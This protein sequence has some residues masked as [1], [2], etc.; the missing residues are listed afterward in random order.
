M[1]TVVLGS[2]VKEDFI[3]VCS[4][5]SS[6]P[7][8]QNLGNQ[9]EIPSLTRE[10]NFLFES[11]SLTEGEDAYYILPVAINEPSPDPTI[12]PFYVSGQLKLTAPSDISISGDNIS[13]DPNT[14]LGNIIIP[15][16]ASSRSIQILIQD[17]S[18]YET[19]KNSIITL[20]TSTGAKVGTKSVFSL[21]VDDNDSPP[22]ISFVAAT[23]TATEGVD[24]VVSISLELDAPVFQN[25]EIPINV[26]G[27]ALEGT[28]YIYGQNKIIVP[29]N[30]L[31][32][33]TSLT[34]L[35]DTSLEA[36]EDFIIEI[37]S[38]SPLPIGDIGTHTLTISDNDAKPTVS[39][40][41]IAKTVT[42]G[43]NSQVTVGITLSSSSDISQTIPFS[44]SGTSTNNV[45][46]TKVSSITI[47]AGETTGQLTIPI[48]NDEI[49]EVSETLIITMDNPANADPSAG[50]DVLTVTIND[51]DSKPQVQFK[52]HSLAVHEDEGSA[53]VYFQLDKLSGSDLNINY[54]VSGTAING[55]HYTLNDGDITIT[56]GND[57]YELSFP[58][59]ESA[60]H[61]SDTNIT[62]T[63][64]SGTGYDIGLKKQVTITRLDPFFEHFPH[65]T[66]G[67]EQLISN[68]INHISNAGETYLISTNQGLVFFDPATLKLQTITTSRGLPSMEVHKS[69]YNKNDHSLIV[70]TSAGAAVAQKDYLT[71]FRAITSA[72]S[73]G[74]TT[75]NFNDALINGNQIILGSS[76][77]LF[78]SENYGESFKHFNVGNTT[79]M[80]S[81]NIIKLEMINNEQ[82][83]MQT[84]NEVIIV[85]GSEIGDDAVTIS[86]D[87][88]PDEIAPTIIDFKL[89]D[90]NIYILTTNGVFINDYK[91]TSDAKLITGH[92]IS[93]AQITGINVSESTLTVIGK[94]S[95]SYSLLSDIA[96]ELRSTTQSN[97]GTEP[98]RVLKGG[99]YIDN[100]EIVYGTEGIFISNSNFATSTHIVDHDMPQSFAMNDLV[101]LSSGEIIMGSLHGLFHYDPATKRILKH[102]DFEN[103][104][105]LDLEIGKES[106]TIYYASKNQGGGYLRN[107]ADGPVR[108]TADGAANVAIDDNEKNFV[109]G[110]ISLGAYFCWDP[111]FTTCYRATEMT[112]V[113]V[114]NEITD[115]VY[116]Q[117]DEYF[118]LT[119]Q[120]T[121]I[122]GVYLVQADGVG[123]LANIQDLHFA[124]DQ[125]LGAFSIKADSNYGEYYLRENGFDFRKDG[126]DTAFDID[127]FIPVDLTIDKNDVMY[128]STNNGLYYSFD[129]GVSFR[130]L[131]NASGLSGD[132]T[133]KTIPSQDGH[134]KVLQDNTIMQTR[135]PLY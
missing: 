77:G 55:L 86:S 38:S 35:N 97:L 132:N 83:A 7:G 81:N 57:N 74:L 59:I 16:G 52:Y 21:N 4:T 119:S 66:E 135:T 131:N 34:I 60:E 62:I 46:Y 44:Y 14:G 113:R 12:V 3:K 79:Q 91:N 37:D 63:I 82:F 26:S 51:N 106:E 104:N 42:E 10:V 41:T 101:Y 5:E 78:I 115:I 116:S 27:T 111:S 133:I 96:F 8:C 70:A 93:G 19:S 94:Y 67:F 75:N 128:L 30:T 105:I 6:K 121:G 129:F 2:C 64:T 1:T 90:E 31:S 36:D 48:L 120:K 25:I 110:T 24:T 18:D 127:N 102:R 125:I 53:R 13:F 15:A 33:T 100:N 122:S 130:S 40:D 56:A 88:N 87:S 95:I 85:T 76:A 108:L 68:N 54:T 23:S 126:V 22:S 73:T 49:S 29:T 65:D 32:F 99:L 84:D 107:F 118:H 134:F 47:D 117:V 114:P 71:S 69:F 61:H 11:A 109:I 124:D 112:G 45:D 20:L 58:I 98:L 43:V 89:R 103:A 28:D 50:Q 92:G 80:S 123:G 9:F 17:D 72:T 39:F